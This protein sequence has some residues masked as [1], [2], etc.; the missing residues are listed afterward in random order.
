MVP[1]PCLKWPL[2]ESRDICEFVTLFLLLKSRV[3]KAEGERADENWKRRKAFLDS[4]KF[5]LT[6]GYYVAKFFWFKIFHEGLMLQGFT[7]RLMQL[8]VRC[9]IGCMLPP[10]ESSNAL[11]IIPWWVFLGF[12]DNTILFIFLTFNQASSKA[13]VFEVVYGHWLVS[14]EYLTQG[15]R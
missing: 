10:A 14:C 12:Q 1:Q 7:F 5:P 15:V 2:A 11:K 6:A 8:S 13:C 3:E 9:G 4:P